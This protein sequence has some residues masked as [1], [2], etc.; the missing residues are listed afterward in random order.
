M[1][2]L[3]P[4]PFCGG[5]AVIR[6]NMGNKYICPIH[7]HKQRHIVKCTKCNASMEYRDKKSAIKAWNTRTPKERGGEK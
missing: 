4:C 5:E 6:V 2:E 7:V 3:K 1:A